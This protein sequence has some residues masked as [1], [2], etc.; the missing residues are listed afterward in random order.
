MYIFHMIL[1]KEKNFKTKDMTF[2][3]KNS[4]ELYVYITDNYKFIITHT[5]IHINVTYL[6]KNYL[7]QFQFQIS[8]TNI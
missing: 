2:Y 6:L 8:K 4:K 5:L 3:K 1:Q 7:K